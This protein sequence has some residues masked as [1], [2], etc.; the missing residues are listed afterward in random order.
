MINRRLN[1]NAADSFKGGRLNIPAKFNQGDTFTWVDRTQTYLGSTLA[2]G[3]WSLNVSFR[4]PAAI[5][6]TAT[7]AASAFQYI[8]DQAAAAK[9]LPGRYRWVARLV[10]VDAPVAPSVSLTVVGDIA[11]GD[12]E[13]TNCLSDLS[14]V[15]IGMQVLGDFFSAGTTV[16]SVDAGTN[17]VGID[18][19]I[20]I[21]SSSYGAIIQSVPVD[22]SP[23]AGV[24]ATLE[25]GTVDVLPDIRQFSAGFDA[26]TQT[27][28]DLEN[29]Q[30][31]M[32][33]MIS[34]GAVQ[35]Y[36]IGNRSVK[37]MSMEALITL[38]SKLKY[39]IA[40]ERRA[41]SIAAGLGDPSNVLVRFTR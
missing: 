7:R 14:Q 18:K 4:G 1:R 40:R 20:L 22:P 16:V 35:E 3:E 10:H 37:K 9:F 25:E 34:G 21:S 13:I 31:A 27:E 41:K 30:K 26:R 11:A 29:V 39:Q 28:I 36:Q 19:P 15:E 23:F 17:T 8:V 38:E 2:D 5:D 32:R 24:Q 12:V 6:L 33:A